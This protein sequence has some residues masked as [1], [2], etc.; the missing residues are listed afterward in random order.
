MR[1]VILL[2]IWVVKLAFPR[3]WR[4]PS[5]LV[6]A[7]AKHETGNFKSNIYIENNSL[8]GMKVPRKRKTT[9][10]GENRGHATYSSR[11]SSIYDYFLR[12]QYFHINY[13]TVHQY[14]NKTKESGYAEDT[15]Y[16]QSWKAHYDSISPIFRAI[17][18]LFL[19]SLVVIALFIFRRDLFDDIF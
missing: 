13:T 4:L 8:F 16:D 18:Y 10:K 6:Y 2:Q 9:V 11:I 12:Q 1:Y 14:I 7:Q 3:Y 5:A 19:P 17:P 15:K